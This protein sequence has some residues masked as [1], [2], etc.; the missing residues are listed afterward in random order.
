M[1][2]L[3]HGHSVASP[4]TYKYCIYTGFKFIL[5]WLLPQYAAR[6]C[7]SHIERWLCCSIEYLS[8][9]I[10]I[11]LELLINS[12]WNGKHQIILPKKYS[13]SN[14]CKCLSGK[15]LFRQCSSLLDA[16]LHYCHLLCVTITRLP[17][18][19]KKS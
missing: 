17:L 4:R 9:F 12:H 19:K 16:G 8:H 11:D 6:D 10:H 3:C 13:F 1:W 15:P 14:F 18:K 7:D 2:H 5:L